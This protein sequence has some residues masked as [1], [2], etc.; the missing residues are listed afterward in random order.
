MIFLIPGYD[1][2]GDAVIF[3][4]NKQQVDISRPLKFLDCMVE[5][6]KEVVWVSKQDNGILEYFLYNRK[7]KSNTPYVSQFPHGLTH[8]LKNK[9]K[10]VGWK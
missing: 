1:L 6:L 3:V 8:S 4:E 2:P 9:F 10:E 7:E 5:G